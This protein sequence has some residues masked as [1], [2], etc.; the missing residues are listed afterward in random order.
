MSLDIARP[1][2]CDDLDLGA[3]IRGT[4][5]PDIGRKRGHSRAA[6][7]GRDGSRDRSR[8]RSRDGESRS[9]M[10]DLWGVPLG[11]QS[12]DKESVRSTGENEVLV[13][14]KPSFELGKSR[15]DG[16]GL[17]LFG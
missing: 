16:A 4:R 15:C 13:W 2:S 5:R 11:Q 9:D 8:D 12:T 1:R 7:L 10:G 14:G 6:L 3:T 17:C